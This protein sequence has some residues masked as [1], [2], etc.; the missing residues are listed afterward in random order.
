MDVGSCLRDKS[1]SNAHQ[2]RYVIYGKPYGNI[3]GNK[4]CSS[5]M[6]EH[7]KEQLLVYQRNC[8]N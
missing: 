3:Y 6:G 1:A 4:K 7:K 5:F 8:S 2:N